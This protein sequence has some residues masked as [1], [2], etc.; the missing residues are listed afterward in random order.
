MTIKYSVTVHQNV[1]K[2]GLAYAVPEQIQ[3]SV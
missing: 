3:N 1:H 2:E